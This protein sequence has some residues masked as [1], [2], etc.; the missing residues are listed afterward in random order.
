MTPASSDPDAPPSLPPALSASATCVALIPARAG[1]KRI[2][3]KNL[4]ELG[5]HPLLAY[6]IGAALRSGVF[7]RVLVSTESQAIAKV[8]VEY[9]AEVPELRPEAFA[10]D[11]SPDIEWVRHILG[12]CEARGERYDCFSLLRPTSPFR[13]AATIDRAW[14]QFVR[15][16][17]ADSLR[18]VQRC[19]EHPAKMWQLQGTRM[20]PLL[21]NPDPA[22][23][24]WHST[25]YQA[26]PEIYVQNAS[27]EIARCAMPLQ[28]GTIA[29]EHIMPF[30][31]EGLEGFDINRPE[32]WLLAEHHVQADPSVLPSL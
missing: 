24:P 25:P 29:G 6:S 13:R 10:G 5:G 27:L 31:T 17:R 9:G 20:Q 1:S 2:A 12:Q 32:D 22:A 16:G 14:Q 30:L 7:S 15:D 21:R 8:A 23:T 4:R 11:R 19:R 18:A 28:H 26:L 3:N